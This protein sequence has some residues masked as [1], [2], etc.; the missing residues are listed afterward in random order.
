MSDKQLLDALADAILDGKASDGQARFA[1]S[2]QQ[3]F[4][5]TGRITDAQR[6]RL[7]AMLEEIEEKWGS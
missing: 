7:E 3:Y 4:E 6:E 5:R 2:V 1:E